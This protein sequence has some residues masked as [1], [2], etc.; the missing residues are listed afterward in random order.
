VPGRARRGSVRE[1]VLLVAASLRVGPTPAGDDEPS[2]P[3][4]EGR[5]RGRPVVVV[6]EA[7]HSLAPINRIAR[8]M[9]G[10]AAR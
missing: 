9:G 10:V 5:L 2:V 7:A 3:D 8:S 1:G 4:L 6:E